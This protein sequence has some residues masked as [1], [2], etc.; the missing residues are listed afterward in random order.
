ITTG[1]GSV[2]LTSNDAARV[3]NLGTDAAGL[4]FTD[5]TLERVVSGTGSLT[6]GDNAHTGSI[7]VSGELVNPSNVGGGIVLRNVDSSI[8]INSVLNAGAQGVQLIADGNDA[9]TATSGVITQGA[10]GGIVGSTLTTQS[11]GGTTLNTP[12]ASNAVG[13]FSAFESGGGNVSFANTGNLT[14][15][16]VGLGTN[17]NV[18]SVT[19][20]TTGTLS[21]TGLITTHATSSN[22]ALSAGG[23]MTLGQDINPGS[24][25]ILTLSSSGAVNM[26]G[27]VISN[28]TS[29]GGA[30]GGLLLTR[31][32][33][34]GAGNFSFTST[35]S[36]V[37]TIAAN[38]NG[39]LSYT[40][41]TAL[42]VGSLS[43]T[44]GI[45]TN[46]QNVTLVAGGNLTLNQTITATGQTIDLT[47]AGITSTGG[48]VVSNLLAIRDN[49][50]ATAGVYA[51]GGSVSGIAA[52]ISGTLS[53]TDA[54]AVAVTSAG[55]LSGIQTRGGSV[56]LNSGSVT[57]GANQITLLQNI[58]TRSTPGA[59]SVATGGTV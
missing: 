17:D 35:D 12:G 28:A 52:N 54:D 3:I 6:I 43:G 21:T 45:N 34:V 14:V 36:D 37:A 48:T 1:G 2:T 53:Y 20:D 42:T 56:T 46:G 51:L 19:I 7:T 4:N 57:N 5:A 58:D 50:T 22:V 11:K 27:K 18:G 31:R 49:N 47:A 30:A 16:G 23:T 8:N 33:G 29:G 39:S 32:G 38:I 10:L 26:G 41:A 13:N 44:N 24:S 59:G 55:G 25:G 9:T 15:S 40:D